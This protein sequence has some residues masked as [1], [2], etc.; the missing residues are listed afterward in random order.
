MKFKL[1]LFVLILNYSFNSQPLKSQ[2]YFK[3]H[4]RD[5]NKTQIVLMHPTVANIESFEL[6]IKNNIISVP[7]FELIGVY[8]EKEEYDYSKSIN[9]IK[10]HKIKNF[11]LHKVS[12]NISEDS[13]YQ[14]NSCTKD[15]FEIFNNSNGIIFTGGPD[16]P[17]SVYS[18]KT[19]L[20]TEITDPYRHYFELSFLF[21]LLG[22]DAY[23]NFDAFL[24]E[25]PKFKIIGICLGMQTMNIA[26]GGT[27]AQDIP[28]EFYNINTVEDVF[29]QDAN[30]IHKNYKMNIDPIN[31]TVYG[32]LHNIKFN[33]ESK[34]LFNLKFAEAYTPL[35][36]SAH[37]QC[38]KKLGSN[39]KVESTSMDGKVIE[40]I[41]HKKFENV[42][43]M[44]FH[45]EKSDIYENKNKFSFKDNTNLYLSEILKKEKCENFHKELWNFLLN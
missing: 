1:T 12:A 23:P 41:S 2:N 13:I 35:V 22:N 39:L 24:N 19:S 20:L 36:Y 37:H 17:P 40:I 43:G 15:F 25:A 14:K 28:S 8:H 7:N 9:Y 34:I 38:I 45:P 32:S 21:H 33:S 3:L 11:Y 30:C 31:E 10:N 4:K 44:Q 18:E 16:I 29:Q 6:L 27:L 5:L 42:Y 26:T